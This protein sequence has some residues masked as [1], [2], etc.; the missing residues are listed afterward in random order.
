MTERSVIGYEWRTDAARQ[1]HQRTGA[2]AFPEGILFAADAVEPDRN[3]VSFRAMSSMTAGR[4]ASVLAAGALAF[5]FSDWRS[6]I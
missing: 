4:R 3:V 6:A 2:G 5:E 1:N